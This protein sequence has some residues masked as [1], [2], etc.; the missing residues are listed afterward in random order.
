MKGS[1]LQVDWARLVP[2]YAFIMFFS[3]SALWIC[4]VFA[5]RFECTLGADWVMFHDTARL[6]LSSRWR[7]IYPGVTT[8]YPFFYPPYFVPFV[9]PLGL[10][11]RS[12]AYVLIILMMAGA[13]TAS[14]AALRLALPGKTPSYRTGVI[15]VL[16]SAS[17][18]STFVSG[19]L[20][21]W[22]LLILVLGLVLWSR[23][24]RLASGAVLCLIMFKPN[25]GLVFPLVFLARRQWPLLA[26]WTAGFLL[27]VMTTLPMGLDTW[28]DYVGSFRIL[29]DTVAGRIPMWKQQT[30]YAFWRTALGNS[31]SPEV[32]TLWALSTVPLAAMAAAA[33]LMTPLDSRHLPRLF[34]TTV[35]ALVCCNTYLFNYDGLLLA[36]PGMVWY[37]Q[38]DNYRSGAYHRIGG[39]A[40]SFIYVW[41]HLTTWVLHGGWALVGPAVGVW[42]IAEAWDLIGASRA[43]MTAMSGRFFDREGLVVQNPLSNVGKPSHGE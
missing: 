34:G 21:A 26:G 8:G 10:L 2:R 28:V 36:L 40:L 1:N 11:P 30:I 39:V 22:Y 6:A 3:V 13:M 31:A 19:Q 23:N 9:A 42:L 41:Q 38:R 25:L 7:E 20:S 16:S 24:R 27:L 14:F 15:V 29:A 4:R 12:W 17:W 37:M 18:S 43:P 35:L 5:S 32:F 33:W